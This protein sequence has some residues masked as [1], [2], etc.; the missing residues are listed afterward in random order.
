MNT[1]S[2]LEKEE[3]MSL[4]KAERPRREPRVFTKMQHTYLK[5]YNMVDKNMFF[6]PRE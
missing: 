6:K 2:P 1:E 5:I 3:Q 4:P